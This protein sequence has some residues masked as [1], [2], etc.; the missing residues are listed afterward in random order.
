MK[1]HFAALVLAL[2]MPACADIDDEAP[3][4]VLTSP[5][6]P[7]PEAATVQLFIDTSGTSSLRD[8][9]AAGP[10]ATLTDAQRTELGASF[11][12]I[13]DHGV[14]EAAACF[15][16]HHFFRYTGAD[17]ELIGDVSVCFSCGGN[18][19]S[20]GPD[21]PNGSWIQE[22]ITRIEALVASMD[23]PT[24]IEYQ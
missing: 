9:I 4:A 11:T 14:G 6:E 24:E 15:I 10:V 2:L 19:V 3:N 12:I 5:F 18:E 17:G 13:T 1:I 23:H 7:F 21:L 22:D 20:P 8:A 16:P